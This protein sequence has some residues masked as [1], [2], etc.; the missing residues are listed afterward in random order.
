MALKGLPSLRCMCRKSN[1]SC[2]YNLFLQNIVCFAI[3]C[4][5]S[6]LSSIYVAPS[7]SGLGRRP[8][9]A[10]VAGSNPVGATK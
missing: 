2:A 6:F 7:S 4:G 1:F 8:F 3:I 10:E 5:L 9:K